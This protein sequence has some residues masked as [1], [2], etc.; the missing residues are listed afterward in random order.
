MLQRLVCYGV[1]VLRVLPQCLVKSEASEV[2]EAQVLLCNCLAEIVTAE[3]Q[4]GPAG[5]VSDS[6]KK[7]QKCWFLKSENGL[8]LS[9][10]TGTVNLRSRLEAKGRQKKKMEGI[11]RTHL[12]ESEKSFHLKFFSSVADTLD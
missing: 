11:P 7:R 12:A 1:H 8:V 2:E 3:R 4:A 6:R 5:H 10:I 9:V